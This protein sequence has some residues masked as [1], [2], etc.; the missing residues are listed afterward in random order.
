[1]I[2]GLRIEQ[3]D[4]E[5]TQLP[6]TPRIEPPACL[7]VHLPTGGLGVGLARLPPAARPRVATV[8]VLADHDLI[9]DQH[10]ASH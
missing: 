3:L 6:E 8:E 5:P 1:M 2:V 7:L 10:Q 4:V 9:A